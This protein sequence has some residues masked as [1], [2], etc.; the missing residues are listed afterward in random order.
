MKEKEEKTTVETE[1]PKRAPRKKTIKVK[2]GI[3]LL[4]IRTGPGKNFEKTGKHTGIGTFELKGIEA[5]E[6]S[7]KGWGELKSGAGWISLDYAERI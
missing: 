3:P 6:G 5:G 2:V 4:V 7:E 1:K